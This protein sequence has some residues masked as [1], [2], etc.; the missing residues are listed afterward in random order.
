[1]T[2]SS[3]ILVNGSLQL[4]IASSNFYTAIPVSNLNNLQSAI[5]S[6]I[7]QSAN[8]FTTTEFSA[9]LSSAAFKKVIADTISTTQDSI[10]SISYSGTTLTIA[11]NSSTNTKVKF[12]STQSSPILVNGSLQLNIASSNF[13][14][15]IQFNDSVLINLRNE[16]NNYLASNTM[17]TKNDINSYLMNEMYS[18]F[19]D[20]KTTNNLYLLD[21]VYSPTYS[22]NSIT[23]K[24]K[25]N[26]GKYK[27]VQSSSNEILIKNNE[28]ILNNIQ[29][30]SIIS[31]QESPEEWFTWSSTQITGLSDIGLNQKRIV[32]PSK[33]TSIT[34]YA[35]YNNKTLVSVDMSLTKIT[36]IPRGYSSGS[37]LFKNSSNL[38]SI[39]LPLSLKS[40]GMFTFQDCSSLTSITIPDGVTSIESY[41]F[42]KCSSL[43]SITIPDGVTSI[44]IYPFSNCSSLTS[45][46]IPD[47]VTSIGDY[48]FQNCISLTSITI[49]DSVTSISWCAF[50]SCTSLK[51]IILSNSLTSIGSYLFSSCSSLTS[52]TI[53]DS[54]TSIGS[55]AFSNCTS[56]KS[57]TI[58]DSVTSIGDYAFYNVSPTCVMNVSSTWDQTL[59][60]NANYRGKFNIIETSKKRII[61]E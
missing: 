28:I 16:I 33:A 6:Y 50:S 21:Y 17:V 44:N 49:P 55:Y 5:E 27:F 24:L 26:I 7:E 29:F 47:S 51:S 43:T 19:E 37:S 15:A 54:V 13:Y 61:V 11:P 52:V 32:L 45:I 8:Q 1:S 57:I 20:V 35:F 4:N 40:I 12:S 3:P 38:V 36:S 41:I 30:P 53:P 9:Q 22:D 42:N 31:P 2:Q 34:N 10:G 56:L 14:T 39:S 59:A 48:A 46:T 25:T 58:P 60:T 23:L 18:F